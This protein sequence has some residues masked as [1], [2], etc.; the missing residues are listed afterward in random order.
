MANPTPDAENLT[1]KGRGRPKGSQNKLGKAVKEIIASAAE[2]I[3]GEDRLVE[4]VQA[5]PQNERAFW[6]SIYPK[7]LPLTLAGDAEN[8]VAIQTIERRIIKPAE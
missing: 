1:N 2:K 5:D 7:L 8:P 3:G 6:T 4:W